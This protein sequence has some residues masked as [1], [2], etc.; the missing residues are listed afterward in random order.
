MGIKYAIT[1]ILLGTAT[2]NNPTIMIDM[3]I[4]SNT[5]IPVEITVYD[6]I[7]MDVSFFSAI[8]SLKT[9]L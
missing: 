8:L 1:P 7:S 2:A 4:E 3:I 5:L 9:S 6:S